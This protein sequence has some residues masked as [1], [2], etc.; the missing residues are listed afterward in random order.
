MMDTI[1]WILVGLI[2]LGVTVWF[3]W[4]FAGLCDDV[5]AIRKELTRNDTNEDVKK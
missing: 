1:F 2:S 4:G 3:L 5:K